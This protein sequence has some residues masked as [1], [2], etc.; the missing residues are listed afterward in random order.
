MSP[1]SDPDARVLEDERYDLEVQI[2]PHDRE[3]NE[4]GSV[5]VQI[6]TG[7]KTGRLRVY[8]NDGAVFDANPEEIFGLPLAL[9]MTEDISQVDAAQ[10]SWFFDLGPHREEPGSFRQS[11]LT[12]MSRADPHNFDALSRPFGTLAA[13]VIIAKQHPDGR[14][15]L[16]AI[17]RGDG[18]PADYTM[19][20]RP[21][22]ITTHG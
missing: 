21:E 3:G 18:W 2:W 13:A 11:L 7:D 12:T 17:A 15:I 8:V 22:G 9:S 19:G 14:R 20:G 4:D 6:D 16:Q 1:T 5:V 10:V